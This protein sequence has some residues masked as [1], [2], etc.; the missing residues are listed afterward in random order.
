MVRD[1]QITG[2]LDKET[3]LMMGRAV[4]APHLLHMRAHYWER[5]LTKDFV[6]M[7]NASAHIW[8]TEKGDVVWEASA[9]L[10]RPV[11]DEI[12]SRRPM[13]ELLA[14]AYHLLS[15]RLP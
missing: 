8:S 7:P 3:L 11:N 2:I 1:Y 14:V 13:G 5:S 6:Q 9:T 4:G 10:E 12:E 15:S